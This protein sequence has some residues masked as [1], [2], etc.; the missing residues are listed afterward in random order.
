MPLTRRVFLAGVAV[1]LLAPTLPA[2]AQVAPG[3]TWKIGWLSPA[4]ATAGA[5]E[6]EALRTGLRDL[7]YTEGRNLTIE[8][9]WADG[10]E[11]RLP[12]LAAELVALKVDVIC[13]AGTPASQAAQRA[14]R[15]IPIVFGR[16]AFPD[17]TGLVASLA[18]PGG[19]LT[20]VTFVGPEY[21]KRLELLREVSPKLTRVGLLYNDHNAASL[22]A[23]EETQQWA[24]TLQVTIEAQ[25]VHDRASLDAALAAVRRSRPDALMTTADPLLASYR[26]PIVEFAATQ[27]LVA[28]YG[29]RSY[30]NAGG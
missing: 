23:V 11:S 3:K 17:R 16:S 29:D 5:S 12:Q 18:R 7:G 1:V 14:T 26:Q 15:T 13:T 21:G 28:M 30:V 8:A 20:G 22:L 2:R 9:R 6:F 25:G 27:R 4:R 19:N 24:R 10:V